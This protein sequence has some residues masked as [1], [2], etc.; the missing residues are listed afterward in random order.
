QRAK[1]AFPLR[2]LRRLIGWHE[3]AE[4]FASFT[5]VGAIET[6]QMI[7]A[8]SVVQFGRALRSF[9][10]PLIVTFLDHVPAIERQSPVLT[11]RRKRIGGRSDRCIETKLLLTR[12]YVRA[13]GADDEGKVAEHRH[14]SR[15]P[16]RR[17]PLFVSDPLQPRAISNFSFE[18]ATGLG[19]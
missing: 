3:R 15:I 17:S 6:D 8:E 2:D 18:L 12:P 13:M 4:R 16:A 11:G 9:P 1:D 19:K 14:G 7:D 10:Q 5:I